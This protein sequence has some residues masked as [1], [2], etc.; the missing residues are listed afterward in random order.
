MRESR[1]GELGSLSV[2]KKA[3]IVMLDSDITAVPT[4]RLRSVQ[5]DMTIKEGTILFRRQYA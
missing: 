3:D 4:D 5:V 2:G 1:E